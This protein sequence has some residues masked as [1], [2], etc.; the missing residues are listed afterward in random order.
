MGITSGDVPLHEAI[1]CP[2]NIQIVELLLSAK[3]HPNIK[4]KWGDTHCITQ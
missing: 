1:V 2:V 4:N 3:A